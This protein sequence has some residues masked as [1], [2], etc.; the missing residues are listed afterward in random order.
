MLFGGT[1]CKYITSNRQGNQKLTIGALGQLDTLQWTT[2]DIGQLGSGEVEVMMHDVGLNFR[3]RSFNSHLLRM[4]F[5][6]KIRM[7]WLQWDSLEIPTNVDLR[8]VA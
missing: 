4:Y 7:C 2:H 6:Q 8:E 3:V 1:Y 5:S